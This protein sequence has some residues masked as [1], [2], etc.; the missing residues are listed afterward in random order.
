MDSLFMYCSRI[1]NIKNGS[2]DTI[3][4]FKN[5]FATVLLV[6][7]FSNNKL[8]PNG[9]LRLTFIS[10]TYY[11]HFSLKKKSLNFFANHA[12]LR[13]VKDS[14]WNLIEAHEVLTLEEND[15]L[16]VDPFLKVMHF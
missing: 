5:Y 16:D 13:L 11:F 10:F 8:N 12:S 15:N 4:T 2:Y 1:K 7:S 9:P 3:H 6:F 14:T